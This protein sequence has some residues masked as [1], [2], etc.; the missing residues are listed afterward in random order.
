MV[1]GGGDSEPEASCLA[2]T[3]FLT[4]RN[5][6]AVSVCGLKLISIGVVCYT[7]KDNCYNFLKYLAIENILF[8]PFP[9]LSH[10]SFIASYQDANRPEN[11]VWEM[12]V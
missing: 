3:R 9:T 6:E 12:I 7:I 2:E 8:S 11:P 5:D 1:V 10:R 4:P